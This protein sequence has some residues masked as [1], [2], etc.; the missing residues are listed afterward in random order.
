MIFIQH[1]NLRAHNCFWNT[2]P[3]PLGSLGPQVINKANSTYSEIGS[4]SFS[5]TMASNILCCGNRDILSNYHTPYYMRHFPQNI[6]K[7]CKRHLKIP[8]MLSRNI[9]INYLFRYL[10]N[11]ISFSN[12]CIEISI[13]WIF[14]TN[15]VIFS[16][17]AGMDGM[18]LKHQG[19]SS[20]SA[21]YASMHFQLYMD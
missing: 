6:Y 10:L 11:I 18:V 12:F 17:N 4:Y 15:V 5:L 8:G 16:T 20:H 7:T 14:S 19:I 9:L 1:L 13:Q 3:P 21:W 2:P